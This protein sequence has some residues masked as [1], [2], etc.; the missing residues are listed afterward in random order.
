MRTKDGIYV[1][2]YMYVYVCMY[3]CIIHIYTGICALV[4]EVGMG[5]HVAAPPAMHTCVRLRA[6]TMQPF[7]SRARVGMSAGIYCQRTHHV[8]IYIRIDANSGHVTGCTCVLVRTRAFAC[9][10]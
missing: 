5:V 7:P 4:Q 10:R 8:G 3:V 1:C 6:P 9:G 2:M